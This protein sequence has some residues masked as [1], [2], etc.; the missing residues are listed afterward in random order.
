M[1]EEGDEELFTN[2][3]NIYILAPYGEKRDEKVK[4]KIRE[5]VFVVGVFVGLFGFFAIVD[6]GKDSQYANL[7]IAIAASGCTLFVVSVFWWLIDQILRLIKKIREIN[8]KYNSIWNFIWTKFLQWKDGESNFWY[9]VVFMASFVSIF[10][11]NI[12][13]IHGKFLFIFSI[14]GI[15]VVII[16]LLKRRKQSFEEDD[17]EDGGGD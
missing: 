9:I 4:K 5:I 15:L 1:N 10:I 13:V 14:L 12:L 8:Q 7:F 3:L 16:Y 6:V 17:D 11:V 2:L